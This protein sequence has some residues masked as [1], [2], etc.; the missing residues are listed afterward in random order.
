MDIPYFMDSDDADS[1]DMSEKTMIMDAEVPEV[2]VA[3][4]ANPDNIDTNLYVDDLYESFMEE[5]EEPEEPKLAPKSVQRS[6]AVTVEQLEDELVDC[7]LEH[8][9]VFNIMYLLHEHFAKSKTITANEKATAK[10][11][12]LG[13]MRGKV[14][15]AQIKEF[16]PILNNFFN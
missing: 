8:G 13:K 9:S 16:S 2:R 12:I 5:L 4:E 3:S 6:K 14:S 7:V 11:R 15:E 10:G 1:L